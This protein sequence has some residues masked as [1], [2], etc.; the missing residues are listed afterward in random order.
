MLVLVE[1]VGEVL[2]YEA[3]EQSAEYILLEVPTVDASAKVIGDLPDRLVELCSFC[4]S[5]RDTLRNS[6]DK[7]AC[8]D[9]TYKRVRRNHT[10][11]LTASPP[12]FP[13]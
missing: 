1:V 9:Q 10:R 4:V 12:Q 8:N 3:I 7:S 13:I 2:R 5:H 11:L 6:P